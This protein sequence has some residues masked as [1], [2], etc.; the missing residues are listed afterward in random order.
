[1]ALHTTTIDASSYDAVEDVALGSLRIVNDANI[2]IDESQPLSKW[3]LLMV[4]TS[5]IYKRLH[6]WHLKAKSYI[7]VREE[8]QSITHN[9][10]ELIPIPMFNPIELRKMK[11]DYPE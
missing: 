9:S 7:K 10:N 1:M 4:S 3:K 2:D 5:K 11:S 6:P 8:V